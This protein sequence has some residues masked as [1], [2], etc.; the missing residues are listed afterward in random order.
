[1]C[2]DGAAIAATP[3]RGNRFSET[4]NEYQVVLPSL[5]TGRLVLNTVFLHADVS[6]RPYKV[7]D[8]RDA[9]AQRSILPE[10]IALGAYRM[11]HVWAV[12]LKDAESTKMLVN[13]GELQVK[14]KRCIV[15]DPANRDIRMK[16]HWLL[17]SVPDED[18]RLALAPFG[19]V[20]DV[21]RE[22]WRAEGVA[23]KVSTTRVVTLKMNA[24]VK[25]DD[26]PHQL[27]V[28]G[29]LALVVVPGRAPL[30]LRCRGTGHIRRECRIPR[31]GVCRR[32]GHE[33]RQCQ[34][35]YASVTAP[36]SSEESADLL[37]DE[38]D[39][40]ET[41][42]PTSAVRVHRQRRLLHRRVNLRSNLSR[43][44]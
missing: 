28:S 12:T 20:T 36:G 43:P 35:T 23:D 10:V 7:E 18:L 14:G 24:G 42:S 19:K 39:S 6:A 44:L 4:D 5:P 9:L 16:V 32:F 21:V 25:I 26:L 15:I 13:T 30:C 1:M 41:A 37:I 2:S 11:S 40:E 31:C 34:R 27:S 22:R 3:G 29:E 8:F 38:A 17:H 33:D